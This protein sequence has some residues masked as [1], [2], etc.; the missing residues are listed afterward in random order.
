VARPATGQSQGIPWRPV[1][2][3]VVRA[4]VWLRAGWLPAA[5]PGGLAVATPACGH[6]C[7]AQICA[8]DG[9]PRCSIKC[10]QGQRQRG[11]TSPAEHARGARR[12]PARRHGRRRARRPRAVS[13][14][15]T[16][17]Q[18][19]A[20]V[21]LGRGVP[22]PWRPCARPTWSRR[23]HGGAAFLGTAASDSAGM[24]MDQRPGLASRVTTHACWG[25]RLREGV[26]ART[27]ARA[28]AHAT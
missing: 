18:R 25:A 26:A 8:S 12:S 27:D 10:P 4:H 21:D 1:R 13:A 15:A 3:G 6:P 5:D 16:G 14:T 17:F 2:L 22:S 20:Q 23:G 7:A 19:R 9:A 11:L 24:K 28:N